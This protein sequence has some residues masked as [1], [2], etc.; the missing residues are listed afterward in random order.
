VFTHEIKSRIAM[1]KAALN[2]KN[3]FHQKI[4][5]EVKC[6]VWSIALCGDETWAV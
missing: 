5:L 3:F 6:F 4:G 2:R 1:A